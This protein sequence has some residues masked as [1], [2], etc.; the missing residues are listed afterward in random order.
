[1]QCRALFKFKIMRQSRRERVKMICAICAEEYFEIPS[2]VERGAKYCSRECCNKGLAAFHKT[3]LKPRVK[4]NCIRCGKE[5]EVIE[6]RKDVAMYCTRK[7][8]GNLNIG[9]LNKGKPRS[10]HKKTNS[11]SPPPKPIEQIEVKSWAKPLPL[12]GLPK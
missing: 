10:N 7:C 3:R 12:F 5:Y 1:M 4:K 11:T 2:K 8:A 9:Q 6:T